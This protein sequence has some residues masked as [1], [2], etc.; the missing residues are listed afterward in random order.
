MR[1]LQLI[2]HQHSNAFQAD[3]YESD[4]AETRPRNGETPFRREF[5]MPG[6]P[7]LNQGDDRGPC[8]TGGFFRG[9]SR[10]SAARLR[11]PGD[12]FPLPWLNSSYQRGAGT[13]PHSFLAG[14]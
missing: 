14:R 3:R 13:I 7:A 8:G 10:R 5:R 4:F 11:S 12:P 1:A 9:P 2:R 6:P